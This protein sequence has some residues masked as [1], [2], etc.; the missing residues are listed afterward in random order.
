MCMNSATMVPCFVLNCN[1]K[2]HFSSCAVVKIK[3]SDKWWLRAECWIY[4]LK[5]S[6]WKLWSTTEL[7]LNPISFSLF[8]GGTNETKDLGSRGFLLRRVGVGVRQRYEPWCLYVQAIF[9]YNLNCSVLHSYT[10]VLCVCISW[11]RNFSSFFEEKD[12]C[13]LFWLRVTVWWLSLTL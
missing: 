12:G 13:F 11:W 4:L 9:W 3:W 6:T 1:E 8:K 10:G 2:K 5:T 7:K